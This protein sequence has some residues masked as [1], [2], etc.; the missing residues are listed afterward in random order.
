MLCKM[1]VHSQSTPSLMSSLPPRIQLIMVSGTRDMMNM[2]G[3]EWGRKSAR[4]RVEVKRAVSSR[5]L[6][7]EVDPAGAGRVVRFE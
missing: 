1:T 2:S 5:V 4:P 7:R 6:L 3:V